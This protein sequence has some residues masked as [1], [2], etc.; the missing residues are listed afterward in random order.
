M[1]KVPNRLTVLLYRSTNSQA[2]TCI[3]VCIGVCVCAHLHRYACVQACVC[4]VYVHVCIGTCVGGVSEHR[5]MCVRVCRHVCVCACV[6]A[7]YGIGLPLLL[8][9]WQA[10]MWVSCWLTA[11]F[12]L[13]PLSWGSP[14][15][16]RGLCCQG[17]STS[18]TDSDKSF[19]VCDTLCSLHFHSYNLC[20]C[21]G[22]VNM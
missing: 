20:V 9:W 7:L 14:H 2:C 10:G 21:G 16:Y 18:H 12:V 4:C 3:Q 5:S 1:R 19:Y 11:C 6:C 15:P 8:H 22:G 13:W 17:L